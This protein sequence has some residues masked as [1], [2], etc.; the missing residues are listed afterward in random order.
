MMIMVM[1]MM[2]DETYVN[3]EAHL[4]KLFCQLEDCWVGLA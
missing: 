4:S 2:T 3:E 1:I